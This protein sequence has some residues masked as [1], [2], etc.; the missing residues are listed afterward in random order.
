VEALWPEYYYFDKG[1]DAERR[2]WK[3]GDARHTELIHRKEVSNGKKKL[4]QP[5]EAN[6][7]L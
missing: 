5:Q 3:G 4:S 1:C 2:N 7:N 6:E